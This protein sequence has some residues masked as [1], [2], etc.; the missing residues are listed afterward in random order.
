MI[1][2][3]DANACHHRDTDGH[4]RTNGRIFR[5]AYNNAKPVH[6]D[7]R[8]LSDGELVE[9]QLSANDWYVR[10]ARRILQ[11]RGAKPEVREKLAAMAFKHA[12]ETR[13][14]RGL[15]ALHVTGGL[16]EA[17]LLAGLQ[18]DREHVRAWTIQLATEDPKRELSPAVRDQFATL[19][20]SDPSSVVRL[21]LASALQR[22]PLAQRQPILQGL[23]AHA[24]DVDDHN[25]PLMFWYAAEPLAEPDAAQALSLAQAGKIPLV[26]S[27]MVRRIA[28][29]GTPAALE[30][31]IA[32]LAKDHDDG[33]QLTILRAIGEGLKGRR[34]VPMPKSWPAVSTRLMSSTSAD[35]EL[36]SHGA[37]RHV[38]R[39][40]GA[41]QTA[42]R[43]GR[44]QGAAGRAEAALECPVGR[45]RSATGRGS[46]KP[47]RRQ[48]AAP[49]GPA[50]AGPVRRC[51]NAVTFCWP[52]TASSVRTKSGTR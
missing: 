40:V 14:L 10:H 30:V 20:K 41:G 35:V 9:L 48:R 34:Q 21:Y 27:F 39:S 26:F 6:V 43:A 8:K 19:A 44:R 51:E 31:L 36:A 11:E 24:E 28:K 15:W 49:R 17:Q 3:Y 46:A 50:R 22:L 33:A 16:D 42:R 52:P 32:E 1:D 2:W 13:R 45:Q 29:I 25:L 5:I 23:L 18:N 47:G 37:G 4:D 12:D 38:R 7:L